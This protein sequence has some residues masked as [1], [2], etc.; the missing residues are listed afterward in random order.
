M[1][2]SHNQK[3]YN[4]TVHAINTSQ[5]FPDI[6]LHDALETNRN[7]HKPP[8][9]MQNIQHNKYILYAIKIYT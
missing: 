5:E 3:Q 4:L 8:H 7:K 1:L 9:N 6:K 2:Y